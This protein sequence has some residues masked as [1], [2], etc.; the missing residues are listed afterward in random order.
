[1]SA[2]QVAIEKSQA[3]TCLATLRKVE[4]SSS[5]LVTQVVKVG[6]YTQD[7]TCNLHCNV[8]CDTSCKGGLQNS[9]QGVHGEAL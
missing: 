7:L 8:L 5:F 9:T 2:L 3:A 6:Y 4:D 1:M